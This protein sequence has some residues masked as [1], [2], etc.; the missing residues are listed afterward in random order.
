ME[1]GRFHPTSE[2]YEQQT[3]T[4]MERAQSDGTLTKTEASHLR[5]FV[6]E[7]SATR[8]ISPGRR[9]KLTYFTIVCRR[10]MKRPW[11]ELTIGD[12]YAGVQALT[13]ARNDDGSLRYKPNT[14]LD[15]VSH[16]KRYALWLIENHYSAMPAE[17]VRKIR[18]PAPDRMTTTAADLLTEED[19]R[20]M[21]EAAKT[22]KDRAFIAVL[23]ESGCRIGELAQMKWKDVR[24]EEWCAW[25]NTDEKTGKPRLI[26]LIM[27]REYLAQ[28]RNDYPL[29]M[30]GDALIFVTNN[31]FKP[32]KYESVIKQLRLIAKRGG[33]QKHIRGHIFRHSRIT[34]LIQQGMSE[35]IVKR[36]AWGGESR[37]I[38]RYAH[39]TDADTA[40]AAAKLAG[41]TPP[42]TR[43][44][45]KAM[46]PIQCQTCGRINGP[47][48]DFCRKCG[49]AI[50]ERAKA[51]VE[52]LSADMRLVM[53]N[54]P[55]VVIE[56]AR[57]IRT[58]GPARGQGQNRP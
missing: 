28:W 8:H 49:S 29:P 4:A 53:A 26:P 34:H 9:Y 39:L 12:L 10:F 15:L 33:V 27:S 31:T 7:I 11:H 6:A 32:I 41:I 20:A 51:S 3:E 56:A 17:K 14:Q 5:E 30:S 48:D 16:I 13:T 57:R 36:V 25:L 22:I 19:I 2:Q 21:I 44:R 46:D 38:E 24:F 37:M 1:N 35:S 55:G 58:E 43:K 54:E 40:A 47:T 50:S 52:S 42:N 23:Y 45:S 18:P